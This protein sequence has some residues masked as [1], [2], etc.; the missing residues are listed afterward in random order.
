MHRDDRGNGDEATAP[1][2]PRNARRRAPHGR[3]KERMVLDSGPKAL[4]L[5]PARRG[6][7]A[8]AAGGRAGARRRQTMPSSNAFSTA[9]VRSRTPSLDR[10]LE[11]WFFTVPSATPSELAISLLL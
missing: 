8:P 6:P 2:I 7:G 1:P 5:R 10:M 4:R 11:T 3:D 9:R